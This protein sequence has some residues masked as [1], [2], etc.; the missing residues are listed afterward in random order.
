MASEKFVY[1][2]VIQGQNA[3]KMEIT[4][5]LQKYRSDI[6]P[7]SKWNNDPFWSILIFEPVNAVW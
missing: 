1:R 5:P 6:L 3:A 7:K 4:L 2:E